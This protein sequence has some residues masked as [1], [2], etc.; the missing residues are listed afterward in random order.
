MKTL[1]TAF[2]L[3]LSFSANAYEPI[4]LEQ[5]YLKRQQVIYLQNIK[6]IQEEALNLQRQE[7][8]RYQYDN[9]IP[10]I[11]NQLNRPQPIYQIQPIHPF[12]Q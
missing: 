1:I 9:Q 3:T 11:I 12:N 10:Q 7:Y 8:N 6:R 5:S 4:D 2:M